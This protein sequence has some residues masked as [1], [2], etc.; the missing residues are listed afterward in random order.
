[1]PTPNIKVELEFDV[2]GIP[3]YA[4]V[5]NDPI[6]GKLDSPFLL[7]GKAFYDVSEY[8][9]T[10]SINRGKSREL[11]EYEA[12]DSTV[13]FN[14]SDRSFDPRFVASPFYGSVVPRLPIR[15]SINGILAYTGIV[16]DW[17][18]EYDAGGASF[19]TAVCTDTFTI[20]AQIPM[21]LEFND[22]QFSG[23]RILEILDRPEVAWPSTQRDIATGDTFLV[24]DL[25]EEGTIALDYFRLVEITEQGQLF[26]AK[27]GDL[28]FKNRNYVPTDIVNFADDGTGVKYQAVGVTYG[29]ELLYNRI[30][31]APEGL[32]LIVVDDLP[33]QATYGISALLLNTI[34]A[35]EETS[36]SMADFL[37]TQYAQPEYRFEFITVQM[38]DLTLLEQNSILAL[39]LGDLVSIKFTPSRIPP[40]IEEFARVVG[41]SHEGSGLS[42][43]VELQLASLSTVPFVLD[44]DALGVLDDG[45]L[46]Y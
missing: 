19:A 21:T 25:I 23:E 26:I 6:K 2:S 41:V 4:F 44:S 22:E 29:S 3:D 8:F 17:N 16:R 31:I 18:L 42:H 9:Q 37:L 24:D 11:D 15:I 39:E 35:F 46:G 33:S 36:Q 13:T 40:A 1:M 7:G 12:G 28:T 5:L 30:E 34:H 38:S 10:M 20:L 14:N 43:Q 32:D 45:T 27:N